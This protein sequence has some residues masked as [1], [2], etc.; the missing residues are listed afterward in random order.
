MV[1][2]TRRETEFFLIVFLTISLLVFLSAAY[3][4]EPK[5]ENVV[6]WKE[7]ID[8]YIYKDKEIIR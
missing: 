6:F 5:T 3:R 1:C 2:R 8:Y 7:I 4:E